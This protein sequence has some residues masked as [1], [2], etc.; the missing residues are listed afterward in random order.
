MLLSLLLICFSFVTPNFSFTD[1]V[2]FIWHSYFLPAPTTSVHVPLSENQGMP[3]KPV[4]GYEFCND[5][6]MK[7]ELRN[8]EFR[9]KTV[10]GLLR[11]LLKRNEKKYT[12][13]IHNIIVKH[14]KDRAIL[15]VLDAHPEFLKNY[16]EKLN[17]HC[18]V[19]LDELNGDKIIKFLKCEH[20]FHSECVDSWLSRS[21]SCPL[22]REKWI[23]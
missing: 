23:L 15:T 7:I 9:G 22:C 14:P 12:G 2:G 19:C 10:Q 3:L 20:V 1:I 5:P 8:L 17:D 16:L 6:Y 13:I 21:A 11:V 18:S 4:F